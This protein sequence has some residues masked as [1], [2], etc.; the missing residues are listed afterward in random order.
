MK[1]GIETRNIV[2]HFK[3]AIFTFVVPDV[4]IGWFKDQ[5]DPDE[6]WIGLRTS[7]VLFD[8]SYNKYEYGQIFQFI[9]AGIGVSILITSI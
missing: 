7:A 6:F 1:I 4:K 2:L 8:C 9:L 3:R 5:P